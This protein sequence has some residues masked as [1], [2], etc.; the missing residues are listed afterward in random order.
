MEIETLERKDIPKNQPIK[1]FII[2]KIKRIHQKVYFTGNSEYLEVFHSKLIF[3]YLNMQNFRFF[4]RK[5]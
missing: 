2:L 4:N 5:G 3:K 1:S